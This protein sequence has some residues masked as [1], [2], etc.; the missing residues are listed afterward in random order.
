VLTQRP[1]HRAVLREH[2]D[3]DSL[4]S[5]RTEF[6]VVRKPPDCRPEALPPLI[7]RS[8]V[9]LWTAERSGAGPRDSREGECEMCNTAELPPE[10]VGARSSV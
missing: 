9:V 5:E 6:A 8:E 3:L 4:I 7:E 2:P 1:R 10:L